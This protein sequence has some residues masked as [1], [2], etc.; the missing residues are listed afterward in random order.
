MKTIFFTLLLSLTLF[1]FDYQLKP[2]KIGSSPIHCFFGLPQAMNT[3]NNGNMAN[4]C[5]V[6]MGSSYIVIDSGP[7]YQ[8]AEQAYMQM[9]KIADLPVKYVI[10]THV[11]DDHWLGNSYYKSQGAKIIGSSAFKDLAIEEMPRMKRR[12]SPE[13]YEKTMQLH[14]ELF[15]D[16]EMVLY[17]AHKKVIIKNIGHKAHT[18]SDIYVYIPSKK[19]VFVGDLV[20]NDRLPSIRDGDLKGWLEAL[21][22]ILL[23]DVKYI[24]GGHGTMVSR[25]SVKMTYEYLKTLR[26]SV[27]T[28]IDEGMDIG[29]VVN[30]LTMDKF[31]NIHL[32]D[33]MHRQN[34]ETAYRMLEWEN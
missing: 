23:L 21:D 9:K 13:A 19:I 17:L 4:S 6:N 20:F 28:L 22:E 12:I 32:Y 10:N 30:T 25:E 2:V 26:E 27:L 7:T 24:V 1:S 8:Y 33:S 29:D 5:F 18:N 34:V 3:Q 14:P 31:K 15:V 11:H 16:E